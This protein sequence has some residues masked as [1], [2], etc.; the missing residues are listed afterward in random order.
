MLLCLSNR[1]PN[2]RRTSSS[3]LACQCVSR[4]PA[5]QPERQAAHLSIPQTPLKPSPPRMPSLLLMPLPPQ[6]MQPQLQ[7]Q[8]NPSCTRPTTKKALCRN[9]ASAKYAHMMAVQ[10]LPCLVPGV[11]AMGAESAARFQGAR[12]VASVKI[13]CALRTVAARDAPCQTVP[14]AHKAEAISAL[15]MAAASAAALRD[16]TN[17]LSA[18]E[19]APAMAVDADAPNLGA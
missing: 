15:P 12:R 5:T 1:L 18:G 3:T 17:L 13:K 14:E 7:H 11:F 9:A 10:N 8:N 6:S 2:P 19:D 4:R 16:A